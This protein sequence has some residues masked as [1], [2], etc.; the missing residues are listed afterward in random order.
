MLMLF[1]FF[2]LM[3]SLF[4]IFINLALLVVNA[5]LL[6]T[7]KSMGLEWCLFVAASCKRRYFM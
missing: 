6:N 5:V 2:L 1:F 4:G 3:T 7:V